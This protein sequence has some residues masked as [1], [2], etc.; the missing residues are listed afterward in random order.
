M[1]KTGGQRAHIIKA[2]KDMGGP[3]PSNSISI[4]AALTFWCEAAEFLYERLEAAESRLGAFREAMISLAGHIPQL[5]C[6]ICGEDTGHEPECDYGAAI[7][8]VNETD[9]AVE[10]T[11]PT[12]KCPDCTPEDDW[13]TVECALARADAGNV[14]DG[15]KSLADAL[16]EG[17]DL[18][19][20]PEARA[21][22]EPEP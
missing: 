10:E 21:E 1:T 6:A 8:L 14:A 2:I 22:T 11:G 3:N 18:S 7:E 16:P 5:P 17:M 12:A 19:Q 15:F 13:H 9:R 20:H 4:D